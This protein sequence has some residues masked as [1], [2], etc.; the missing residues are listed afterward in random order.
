[1]AILSTL[2]AC[3]PPS[4]AVAI[5]VSTICM[6]NSNVTNLDGMQRMFALLCMRARDANSFSQQ[7]LLHWN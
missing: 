6:A 5:K 2:N 3:L 4:K 1:M 7:G